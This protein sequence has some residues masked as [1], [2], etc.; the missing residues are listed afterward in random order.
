MKVLK[1]TGGCKQARELAEKFLDKIGFE[2]KILVVSRES[3][4]LDIPFEKTQSYKN[5]LK[6][7]GGK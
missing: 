3:M 7:C 4:S 6:E 1:V 5:L 2:K